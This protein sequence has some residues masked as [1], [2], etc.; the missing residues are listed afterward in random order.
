MSVGLICQTEMQKP[1]ESEV[2]VSSF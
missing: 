1:H 2:T